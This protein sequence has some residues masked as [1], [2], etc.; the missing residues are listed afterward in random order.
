MVAAAARPVVAALCAKNPR[1][2]FTVAQR[3][4]FGQVVG[5]IVGNATPPQCRS[6]GLKPGYL[7]VIPAASVQGSASAGASL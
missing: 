5:V 7:E 4:P 2:P 6:A 3:H 1:I